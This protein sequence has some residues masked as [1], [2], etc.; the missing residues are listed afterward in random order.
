M[1]VFNVFKI[2]NK[3]EV[4]AEYDGKI[5]DG[6]IVSRGLC[7]LTVLFDGSTLM[8]TKRYKFRDFGT[9]VK[10]KEEV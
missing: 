3:K 7:H 9:L 1:K 8:G 2:K 4:T 6:L 10:Y 5:H